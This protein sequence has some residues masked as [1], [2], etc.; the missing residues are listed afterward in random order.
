MLRLSRGH[1]EPPSSVE[2]NETKRSILALSEA[3]IQCARR[4]YRVLAD[5][6]ITGFFPT[7]DYTYTQYLFSSATILAIS[8]LL[9][10][11]GE[12]T[13]TGTTA[14]ATSSGTTSADSDD[15]ESAIEILQ[16]LEQN[17]SYTAAEFMRH[18]EATKLFLKAAKQDRQINRDN[19]ATEFAFADAAPSGVAG[20]HSGGA[21][22][23]PAADPEWSAAGE[24][25]LHG[26]LCQSDFDLHLLDSSVVD[27]AYQ[28]FLWPPR[29]D[30][31]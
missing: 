26:L 30:N 28:N 12:A 2:D 14:T 24:L 21:S 3:C 19:R 31:V 22:T 25:S 18:A 13:G 29:S 15:F 8:S 9:S 4:S 10:A 11:G 16:Q 27:D 23:H 20:D 17:G 6:W 5:S 1:P 7:F